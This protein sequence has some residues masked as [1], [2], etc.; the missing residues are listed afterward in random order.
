M[1]ATCESL[2]AH[3]AV[4]TECVKSSVGPTGPA[5]PRWDTR[6]GSRVQAVPELAETSF[7]LL[8]LFQKGNHLFATKFV[9]LREYTIFPA[10]EQVQTSSAGR[11]EPRQSGACLMRRAASQPVS[12]P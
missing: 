7:L 6:S 8:L 2:S 5:L 12:G 3:C 10:W 11:T 9:A 4:P 1:P